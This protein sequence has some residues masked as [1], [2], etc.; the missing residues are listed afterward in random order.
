MNLRRLF[1]AALVVCA[2]W[3]PLTQAAAGRENPV[4]VRT[5]APEYPRTLKEQNVSGLVMVKCT[6]D[7]QGNVSEASV[8]KSSNEQFDRFAMDAVKKWKFKPAKQDGAAISVQV[9]IPIKFVVDES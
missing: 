4:P 6:I 7:E 3:C 2:V 9:T 1:A 8:A 5:V